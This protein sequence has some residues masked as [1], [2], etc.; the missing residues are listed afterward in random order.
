MVAYGTAA[1]GM[2]A[3]GAD[4]DVTVADVTNTDAAD[5]TAAD[6]TNGTAADSTAAGVRWPP[7][8]AQRHRRRRVA[9]LTYA[10]AAGGM[11]AA[12]AWAQRRR[13]DGGMT[14]YCLFGVKKYI[15]SFFVFMP[16][17]AYYWKVWVKSFFCSKM[18]L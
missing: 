16:D 12:S 1:Y 9:D 11:A 10:K 6:A 18:S 14:A 17:L 2:T 4:A 5:G 7:S 8:R 3:C 13:R 15:F